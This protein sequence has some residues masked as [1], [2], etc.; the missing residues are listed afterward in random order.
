MFIL[1]ISMYLEVVKR[2]RQHLK[3]FTFPIPLQP[4][5][6]QSLVRIALP[7]NNNFP[8]RLLPRVHKCHTWKNISLFFCSFVSFLLVLVTPFNNSP[9]SSRDLTIFIAS[10]I[11]LFDIISEVVSRAV[12]AASVV[13]PSGFNTLLANNWSKFFIN[14]RSTLINRPINL[15]RNPPG[16]SF[17]DFCIFENFHLEIFC[18]WLICKGNISDN[19]I[20]WENLASSLPILFDDNLRGKSAAFFV[21]DLNLFSY[22]ADN[23][24]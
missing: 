17:L 6:T 18:K 24:T 10:S 5:V 13:N 16:C 7:P 20:L 12:Y 23:F 4:L 14:V 9:E 22:E 21:A 3:F 19:N 1:N 15:P 2:M 11:S 8:S